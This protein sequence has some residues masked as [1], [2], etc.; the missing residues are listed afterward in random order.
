M[1]NSEED[2]ISIFKKTIFERNLLIK[3]PVPLKH[4]IHLCNPNEYSTY[5]F[6]RKG[7]IGFLKLSGSQDITSSD[8]MKGLIK[9][10]NEMLVRDISAEIIREDRK[11]LRWEQRRSWS[12]RRTRAPFYYRARKQAQT[13]SFMKSL[14]L[15]KYVVNHMG[16]PWRRKKKGHPPIY[17]SKKLATVLL[18]KHYHDLSYEALRARII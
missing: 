11:L 8:F 5:S 9:E 2:P 18:V 7:F 10:I 14:A 13:Y 17:S 3:N 15:A 4:A 16:P 12:T 1:I 6:S